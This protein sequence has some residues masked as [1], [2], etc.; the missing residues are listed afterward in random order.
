MFLAFGLHF[1]AKTLI[2]TESGR[3][4][5]LDRQSGALGLL[6]VT[7]LPARD[8]VAGQREALWKQ[9]QPALLLISIVNVATLMG[10]ML[11][12]SGPRG[13]MNTEEFFMMAVMLLGGAAI[14]WLDANALICL[15]M[16]RG[17]NAKKYPRSVLATLGQVLLP[18][19]LALFFFGVLGAGFI[20]PGGAVILILFWFG[21]GVAIDIPS[22]AFAEENLVKSLRSVVS[23]GSGG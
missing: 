14:L 11:A 9:F 4:F 18:P 19:W 8:I 13:S 12:M 20:E 5:H 15:G 6:L 17:L 23:E 16:W 3:R 7:P 21:V 1:A 10:A 22:I 2:A